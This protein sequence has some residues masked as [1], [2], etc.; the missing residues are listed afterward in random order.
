MPPL[1]FGDS[2]CLEVDVNPAGTQIDY[3]G[4][5]TLNNGSTS[6]AY[7]ACSPPIGAEPYVRVF[8]GDV[9]AG[10]SSDSISSCYTGG[11]TA[12]IGSFNQG[13]NGDL[14]AGT[15][16]SALATGSIDGFASGQDVL[17]LLNPSPLTFANYPASQYG[18]DFATNAAASSSCSSFD[19]YAQA[20]TI[21]SQGPTDY[22][23]PC[24]TVIAAMTL[25]P[26]DQYDHYTCY[27]TSTVNITGPITYAIPTGTAV[28]QFPSFEVVIKGADIN[29]G[30]TVGNLAG[31][32]VAEFD[33]TT[34]SGGTIND[35]GGGNVDICPAADYA[36]NT[37]QNTCSNDRL[38][39][40]GSFVANDI[41]F[42]RTYGTLSAAA[43]NSTPANCSTTLQECYD[44]EE[45]DYSPLN[46]LVPGQS[47]IQAITS[48][49]PVL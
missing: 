37:P 21:Q 46:W 30:T 36:T 26:N 25:G 5:I 39:I 9:I 23:G 31:E 34:D 42:Y 8:G 22:V 44:A 49:P 3:Q 18:G 35:Y 45:F 13:G 38:V 19:Y 48:L 24:P 40:D 16:T 33:P 2:I 10:T 20:K 17:N 14:G 1:T 12:G 28:N 15:T 6:T 27:S 41:D 7:S 32:Y 43:N 47:T 4:N 29:I 11:I